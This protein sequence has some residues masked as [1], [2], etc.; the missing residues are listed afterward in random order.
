SPRLAHGQLLL[1]QVD[2]EDGVGLLAHV[3]DA[4]EIGVELLELALHCDALLRRKQREL[5]F[6]PQAP[7]L[8]QALD[9]LGDRAPVREQAAEPAV[10]DVRHAYALGVFLDAVLRLL[11]GADEQDR[12]AALGEVAHERLGLVQALRGLLQVDDVDAA[13]LAEDEALHLG[14]PAAGLVTEVDSGL[15][16]LS[17][18]DGQGVPFSRFRCRSPSGVGWNRRTDCAGTATRLFRRVGVKAREL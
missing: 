18:A 9:A 5:A 7:Q 12:A 15:Q 3:R 1:A 11:L 17:H 4:A 6:V 10:V 16:E 14:I 2:D 8:V 13:A